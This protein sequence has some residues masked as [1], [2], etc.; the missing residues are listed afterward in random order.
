M[1]TKEQ[2]LTAEDLVTQEV[3]VKE[4]GGSVTVKGMTG[5]ER[6]SFEQSIVDTKGKSTTTN[7]ANIRAR[8]CAMTMVDEKGV[9]IFADNEIVK[10]GKKSA[11]AL[12]KVFAVAQELNGMS[13][14]DVEELAKNSDDAPNEDSTSS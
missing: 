3:E 6:D 11:K 14:K 9:R 10:L 8:L 5:T 7:L 12:D 1:L 4:W 2:I 13:P